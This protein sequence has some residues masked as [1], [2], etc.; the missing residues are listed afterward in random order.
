M[1]MPPKMK[2]SSTEQAHQFIENVSFGLIVSQSLEASHL[3]FLLKKEQGDM[4]TLYCHFAR[5]NGHWKNLDGNKVLITFNGPHAYIS[6]S[7]YASSPAVPTWNYAAV[8]VY[9]KVE[10]LDAAQTL[11]VAIQSM[12]KYEPA[13]AQVRH[14]S[15]PDLATSEYQTKLSKAIVGC[16]IVISQI[17][18]KLKLGQQRKQQDQLGVVKG[19]AAENDHNSQA[20][21]SFMQKTGIGVG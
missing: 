5:A 8:H 18:G 4:G 17:D 11:D 20:L 10:L 7:W 19:L 15:E 1:Y 12:D 6:P 21:L 13:Q 16:K 14:D 2:M 3:P 9:G